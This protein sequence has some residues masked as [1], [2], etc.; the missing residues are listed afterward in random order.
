M[1]NNILVLGGD[2]RQLYL[3]KNLCDRGFN[4]EIF[5]FSEATTDGL[6]T[7]KSVKDG[8]DKNNIVV[9][10]MPVTRNN[11]ILNT[12]LNDFYVTL[13]EIYENISEK[14]FIFGGMINKGFFDTGAKVFD[15]G[16]S[17]ELLVKNAV[18]TAEAV[19]EIIISST[20]Y[21]IFCSD[22]LVLGYGRIGKILSE[23]LKN[24]GADVT[25]CMRKE[26][27]FAMC[28]AKRMNTLS[29]S[30]LKDNVGKFKIIVN[31]V[32]FPVMDKNIIENVSKNAFVADLSSG[33]GGCD[34]EALAKR[35]IK[36]IRALGLPGKFSP[37]TSGNI[38]SDIII[39]QIEKD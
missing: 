11:V 18:L 4:A 19:L 38:I 13:E 17:E 24:L 25:V 7:A 2:K 39:K 33:D 26:Y 35:E 29:Y 15:Y 37:E 34:F 31:T 6:P 16:K 20:P 10:P 14:H 30:S 36:H 12:P 28:E 23:Y 22:A 3:A 8:L 21:S 27:D 32:P 9:L 1:K 5:G